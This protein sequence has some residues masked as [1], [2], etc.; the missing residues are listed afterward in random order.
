[1]LM[2]TIWQSHRISWLES[3]MFLRPVFM[4]IIPSN[5]QLGICDLADK[6]KGQRVIHTMVFLTTSIR[7]DPCAANINQILPTL[8]ITV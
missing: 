2:V 5:E 3:F 8:K 6:N 4:F 1:M 7:L